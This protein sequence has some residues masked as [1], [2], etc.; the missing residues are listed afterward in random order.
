MV[1]EIGGNIVRMV[2]ESPVM[3]PGLTVIGEKTAARPVKECLLE[4][5]RDLGLIEVDATGFDVLRI[6]AGTPVFGKEIT[7]KNL[8]QEL[9]RDDRAINFIKG[10]YLG[11]GGPSPASTLWGTSTSS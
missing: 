11:Q 9:G 10:C 3:P 4:H 5:G 7:E 1:T 8:P 2:R 6:E